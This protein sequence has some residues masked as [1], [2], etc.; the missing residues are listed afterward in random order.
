VIGANKV[1]L[2]KGSDRAMLA[3][4]CKDLI[5]SAN[6]H[7]SNSPRAAQRAAEKAMAIAR[8][9]RDKLGE[10]EAALLA[11]SAYLKMGKL[12]LAKERLSVALP[13][14]EANAADRQLA[15]CYD[16]YT[17]IQLSDN[18]YALALAGSKRALAIPGLSAMDRSRFY[19]CI[20]LASCNMLDLL[21]ARRAMEEFALPEAY[22]SRDAEIIHLMQHM[23]AGFEAI[24][25]CVAGGVQIDSTVG[26]SQPAAM[27]SMHGYLARAQ[28]CIDAGSHYANPDDT[29]Q[30]VWALDTEGWISTLRD[31]IDV[32]LPTL[33]KALSLCGNQ[34]DRVACKI[35]VTIAIGYRLADRPG[36]ALPWLL[37]AQNMAYGEQGRPM[38]AI[39]FELSLVYEALGRPNEA[40]EALR[41]FSELHARKAMNATSWFGD[42]DPV[43][44]FAPS[45]DLA[46][47][48]S[49][50]LRPI[51][52]AH[53]RRALEFIE[54][55]VEKPIKLND[56]AR[57]CRV[58]VKT[59]QN[60][61][62]YYRGTNPSD[63]I[64]EL[65]LKR[66]QELLR[67]TDMKI[68][69]VAAR[70][71]YSSG[72]NLSRDYRKQFGATPSHVRT[73]ESAEAVMLRPFPSPP[74]R[75]DR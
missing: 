25:A 23:M 62:R 36:D 3:S 8:V 1:A 55:N 71:G 63:A 68:G 14:F 4:T 54:Q 38:R 9:I 50:M 42:D 24:H 19:V 13:I 33:K 37:E 16:L 70:I 45:P 27:D 47:L 41:V 53:L 15:R 7:A 21:G 43:L 40:L 44:P 28:R 61:F 11:S 52:P 6:T 59:L 67:T 30:A 39:S 34:F 46:P 12:A 5:A 65:R 57:E 17:T 51:A 69:Q 56:L 73:L 22:A 20:A 10:A 29:H 64:R 72:S 2:L 31:G 26:I 66:A 35:K 49:A 18:Y 58:S 75:V 48:R 74:A 60:A 32:S